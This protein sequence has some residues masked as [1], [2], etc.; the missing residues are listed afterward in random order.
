MPMDPISEKLVRQAAVCSPC[1]TLFVMEKTR[2]FIALETTLMTSSMSPIYIVFLIMT[3]LF[4]VIF[5]S[6]H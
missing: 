1:S 2:T 6:K 3:C 5:V 4:Q